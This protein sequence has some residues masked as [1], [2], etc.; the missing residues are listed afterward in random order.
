MS[1]I[2]KKKDHGGQNG[3]PIISLALTWSAALSVAILIG[4]YYEMSYFSATYAKAIK[5]LHLNLF[6]EAS[7]SHHHRLVING[8]ILLLT[9]WQVG[10]IE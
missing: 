6:E 7:L 3:I 2:P 4:C 10:L 1:I 9:N 5:I 8:K